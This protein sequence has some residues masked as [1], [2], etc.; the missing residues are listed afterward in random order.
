[1]VVLACG[2]LVN[3]KELAN[4][5]VKGWLGVRIVYLINDGRALHVSF[6][7]GSFQVRNGGGAALADVLSDFS[8]ASG[9]GGSGIAAR[10]EGAIIS[11]GQSRKAGS[12]CSAR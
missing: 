12:T 2:Q 4:L 1:M 6:V 10:G 5:L 9:K 7:A 3:S 8:L 11:H